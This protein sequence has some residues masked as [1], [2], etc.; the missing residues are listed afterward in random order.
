MSGIRLV[1][2]RSKSR[3]VAAG[4]HMCFCS[5]IAVAPAEPCT[6][7]MQASRTRPAAVRAS[8]VRAGTIASRNGRATVT[9]SPFRTVRRDRC[10]RVM[11]IA[12]PPPLTLLRNA[13]RK[14][15]AQC[16]PSA[17]VV[18]AVSGSSGRLIRNAWLATTPCTNA[19]TV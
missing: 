4:D 2:D 18:A 3:P 8:A 11:N 19:V 15:A 16:R 10:F 13:T 17:V 5:P 7:S 9:P 1:G 14:P 6:I 12:D